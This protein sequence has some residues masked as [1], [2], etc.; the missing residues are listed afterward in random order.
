MVTKDFEAFQQEIRA[1][2]QKGEYAA[3]LALVSER[4]SAYPD[5]RPLLN[6]WRITLSAE[7][8]NS[9]QALDLLRSALLSGFW[10]S[11]AL[12]RRNPA[13]K[14]LQSMPAFEELVALNRSVRQRDNENTYP[15]L[16][17][18]SEGR[19]QAG[20]APCPL[21][22]GLHANACMAADSLPFWQS[23][24][25]EG[26]LVAAPQ[27]SQPMWKGAYLWDDR[28]AAER[29]IQEQYASLLKQYAV[30][31]ERVVLAGHALGG[32]LTIGLSLERKL[33]VLGFI[34]IGAD[35]PFVQERDRWKTRIAA[36]APGKLRGYLI[37]GAK[38]ANNHQENLRKLATY[39]N[40]HGIPCELEI[41]P[42]AGHDFAP[43][44]AQSLLRG[45][46]FLTA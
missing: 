16:T 17:L 7:V 14:S 24:A 25:Q 4:A 20:G 18:R 2:Y 42:D 37:V 12:L 44:Y 9:T 11:E 43:A 26:W 32:D 10:Y 23:A 15:L 5:Q 46:A 45:L 27:S 13:L 29:Q 28:E 40:Q 30:D 34:A 38:D 21:F 3:A 35:G 1:Y 36:S 8:G 22:I 39:L 31:S 33:P 19:C 6:Y 41:V